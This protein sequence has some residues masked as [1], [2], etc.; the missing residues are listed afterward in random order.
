MADASE[1]HTSNI[2]PTTITHSTPGSQQHAHSDP[3]RG[4]SAGLTSPTVSSTVRQPQWNA[5]YIPPP[6]TSSHGRRPSSPEEAVAGVRSPEELLRR[7]SLTAQASGD[8]K[9][10]DFNPQVAFPELQLSGNVISATFCVP[11]KIRYG[12]NGQWDLKCRTG[13]SALFDSFSYLASPES[14][15]KHTLVGWTGEINRLPDQ[16][17][18]ARQADGSLAGPPLNKASAPIPVDKNTKPVQ[19]NE[20]AELRIPLESRKAL[21]KMLER[22]HGGCVEPVWLPDRRL[23]D[24]TIVLREQNK[25]RRYGEHELFTLFHYKQNEPSD[26]RAAKRAYENYV[27]MNQTFADAILAVYQPGDVVLIH[28]YHLLLLP[29]LLRQ[30]IPAM[31]IGFFLHIPF[32]SNE[33]YRCLTK[34]KEI[35]EGVLG[36]NMIGFQAFSYSRH[37]ASCCS[38]LLDTE[39]SPAG[40]DYSGVH[41][42]VDVFPI[43]INATTTLQSAFG[44]PEIEEKMASLRE[45]YRD[46]KIIVG[47]DRLDSVR[48]VV[49]KLQ[50][51]EIFLER[52]PEWHGKVVLIQVT[53]P[54]SVEDRDER[55]DKT[56][57]KISDLVARIN[58]NYG[59]LSFV[60]VHHYPQ[61]LAK[62]EYF[63]LLRVA[64]LGLITSVRDGMNTT[65]LEYV[66]CQRDHHSPLIIS[67]FSG[68]AGSLSD[69]IHINPWDLSGVADAVDKAL[70]MSP[71]EK[72]I[73]HHRLYEYVK[74]H[75]IQHWTN[76]YLK[77]LLTNLAAFDQ[78]Q[79]TPLLD[80]KVLTKRYRASTRRLFMFDY[81][82][83]LT[84][85]V[86]DPDAAI[87]SDKVIRTLKSLA[88]NPNNAV[89]I[90]SGRDQKFLDE[91]MGHISALGLSAEHGSFVRVP[92]STEWENLTEKFDMSWQEQVMSIFQQYTER[93][94]GSF[95]ERK[96]IALTWHYRRADPVL[97]P[98]NANKCQHELDSVVTPYYDVEV[99]TGKANLEV[100]PKFV[101]KGEI[102]KRLVE[103]YGSSAEAEPDFVL[104]LGDDFTDE[105]M[106]RSLR[107]SKVNIDH[108][109]ACTIGP[110]EKQTL[111]RWH[112]RAPE[113]VVSAI[114]MLNNLADTDDLDFEEDGPGRVNGTEARL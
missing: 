30:R 45:L 70:K 69:A 91:W 58:G 37:F 47:R 93:T 35:L 79:T 82:G 103:E 19:P 98:Y 81:D 4:H 42:A 57:A 25:W 62:E 110:S 7:L 85:I 14:A 73:S 5:N 53:S 64:D 71:L 22:D 9:T 29:K 56:E 100:R 90:I 31:Y 68:T 113:D 60:P 16:N 65:A 34:R 94:M 75:T 61:Y 18:G 97:G 67:E 88:S 92:G 104:C 48:G 50:A 28:D 46:K 2:A 96:K 95:I 111:A 80:L 23:E 44:S 99:M 15:W 108:V 21:E 51:F 32:P 8:L 89:W 114:A 10:S 59:T 13:T 49:Q 20:V 72:Q 105:D 84:P 38:R 78:N 39:A 74:G 11:Y 52:H 24:D 109:F 12:S 66:L 40:V 33:Y 63:A 6:T 112:L 55:G 17:S 3:T 26:G 107:A 41:S 43:G 1:D 87:P 76:N 86:K 102:A 83:T 101:N 77:R 106:F 27:K 54:T 36:S